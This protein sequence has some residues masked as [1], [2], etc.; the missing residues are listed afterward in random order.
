MQSRLSSSLYRLLSLGLLAL[1]APACGVDLDATNTGQTVDGIASAT[2]GRDARPRASVLPHWDALVAQSGGVASAQWSERGTP[3]TVFGTL[4]TP[5]AV[6]VEAARSFIAAHAKLLLLDETAELEAQAGVESPLG[7][8]FSFAQRHEGLPVY[9]AEIKVSLNRAGQIIA[10]NNTSVPELAVHTLPAIT[11]SR[12]LALALATIPAVDLRG[13]DAPEAPELLIYADAGAPVL[14][15]RIVVPTTGPTLQLFIDARSGAQV[16][17]SVDLNRY[18]DGTGRV[19]KSNAVVA[20]QNNNL[21]DGRDAASAVPATA[22]STVT[23]Q[24]LA[25][26]TRLDGTFASSSASR[27]RVTSATHTFN[28]LRDTAGFNETMGYFH[29]DFAQR[30]IQALGFTNVNNRRQV[31]SVDR[32]TADNS[33]YSP[34]NKQI[35]FGTGGVDDAEDGEVI[36][37]EYG[38]SIQ[39]NQVPGFGA[40]AEGGAMGEGF[41]DYLAATVVSSLTGDFQI[42][43]IAEWDAT[44]YAAG[45]PHC[46]RRLDSTKHYPQDVANEVHD[47]GE[48]WSASLFQIRT[49]LGAARADKLILQA[50]FLLSSTANF[51]DGSNALV[52]AAL[53]LGFT[54]AEV[55]AVRTILQNRGFTVTV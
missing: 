21:V 25:G 38:H 37:H 9:G 8:H 40:R 33:F 30:Y 1:A 15:Y 20:T 17:E 34:S 39:D 14:A 53:N 42:T 27:V 24:G 5:G 48:M 29:I 36:I 43:C 11:A 35:T 32:T 19:F 28:F 22:Y 31:F 52:T 54:A 16:G 23:L 2:P 6:S 44:S 55:T 26:N 46:L 47:D 45:V 7:H 10:L 18:I 51:R 3:A 41:G 50:H 12:A 13:A 4:S 49:A